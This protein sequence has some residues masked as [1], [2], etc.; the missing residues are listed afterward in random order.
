VQ[1]RNRDQDTPAL[2]SKIK[3]LIGNKDLIPKTIGAVTTDSARTAM[4]F[5]QSFTNASNL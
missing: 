5:I 1:L 4:L 2:A 3:Q